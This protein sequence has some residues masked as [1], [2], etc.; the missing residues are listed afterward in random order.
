VS[1]RYGEHEP[2]VLQ[3]IN[4]EIAAGESVAIVGSSGCGKTTL[5]H[6]ILGVIKPTQG[7]I[8]I[9]DFDISQIGPERLRRTLGSVTQDD[10][11]F[12]GSIAEN[13]SFFE[14]DADD[15]WVEE[16]ARLA[17]IHE[18]IIRMPMAYNTLVGHMGSVLSGGQIQRL[19]LA[20]ALYKRPKVLVLDE[21]TSHLDLKREAMV[22]SSICSLNITRILVA[23]RPQTAESADRIITMQQ[24]R[25]VRE[26][27]I[28]PILSQS[29]L[30]GGTERNAG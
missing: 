29:G 23:H 10:T 16:C 30:E 22:N 8:E 12:A 26:K 24:G 5:L 17:S 20:R 25:I 15:D 21:A 2:E 1:F 14:S 7:Q 13:I 4:L 6:L 3:D 18:E 9:G 28:M 11:L 19:L 27:R